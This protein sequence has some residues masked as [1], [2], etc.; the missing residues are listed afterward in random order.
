MEH[1]GGQR[2]VMVD[3]ACF[4][5]LV[6]SA[7]EVYNRETTGLLVGAERVRALRGRRTPVV[8]VEA[9]VPFQTAMRNVTWVQSGNHEAVRR[10][11]DA[12]GSLGYRVLG[13]FHSHTNNE[14]GLSRADVDYAREALRRM[15]GHAPK[16]WLELVVAI[17]RKEYGRPRRP[18]WTW[19]D[20]ARKA[21]CTVVLTPRTGFDLTI[22]GY[23]I[24]PAEGDARGAGDPRGD[25]D[26]RVRCDEATVYMPWSERYWG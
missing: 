12:P 21:G 17:K 24:A 20:Y 7:V 13:E 9:A 23:W 14:H 11:R 15:N 25:A 5:S 8:A 22:A 4:L 6:N 18:G 19:R 2:P 1:A 10:A 3:P 26:G 16:R